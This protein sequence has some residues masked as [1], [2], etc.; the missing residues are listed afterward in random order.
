MC[1]LNTSSADVQRNSSS[2]P[3]HTEHCS[4]A[5]YYTRSG[6]MC[7]R[8][9]HVEECIHYKDWCKV[10]QGR[11][12]RTPSETPSTYKKCKKSSQSHF[13]SYMQFHYYTK[14]VIN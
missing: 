8:K 3:Q 6:V 10:L 1:S 14:N 5:N 12:L 4:D 13:Y 2:S 7:R 11:I 9:L